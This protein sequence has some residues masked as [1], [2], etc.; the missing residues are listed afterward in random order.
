MT[1]F[2]V[3]EM[4][5]LSIAGA[6]YS[7]RLQPIVLIIGLIMHLAILLVQLYTQKRSQPLHSRIMLS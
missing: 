6:D 5:I 2:S 7:Y 1:F 4:M 3:L